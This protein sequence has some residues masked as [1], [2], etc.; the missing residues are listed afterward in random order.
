MRIS[1]QI[2]FAILVIIISAI[3]AR[4]QAVVV[5]QLA[6]ET[7]STWEKSSKWEA[8]T[9]KSGGAHV[10]KPMSFMNRS[11]YPLLAVAQFYIL[12]VRK[13][14]AAP[15]STARQA[16]ATLAAE[17][18][19]ESSFNPFSMAEDVCAYFAFEPLIHTGDLLAVQY[20]LM[21]E[22]ERRT[23]TR[24]NH[25]ESFLPTRPVAVDRLFQ[26]NLRLNAPDDPVEGSFGRLIVSI[27][28]HCP[29]RLTLQ[30]LERGEVV[31]PAAREPRLEGRA[32]MD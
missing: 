17:L 14:Q 3:G 27:R 10:V 26:L 21:K 22:P 8:F 12:H 16:P 4:A 18:E 6:A 9:A 19:H 11:G 31:G 25:F 32:V 2:G 30:F 24:A 28:F 13:A 5:D 29:I 1:K 23:M 7:G 15:L 20:G